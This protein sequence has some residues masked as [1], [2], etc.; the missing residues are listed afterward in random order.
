MVRI[1]VKAFATIR[2]AIGEFGK[3]SL[4]FPEQVTV[5]NL[6]EVLSKN[7]GERFNSEVLDDNGLPKKTIKIFVNGRDIEFLDGLSTIL[8][9]EDEVALIP[10]IAGG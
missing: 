8:K 5:K 7:F 6:I 9:D 2:E 4:E 1:T 3:I 10:P